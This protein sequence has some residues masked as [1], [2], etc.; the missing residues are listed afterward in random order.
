M[1]L[2]SVS[3]LSLGLKHHEELLVRDLDLTL[4]RG[5]IVGLVGES[6]SG[7]TMV[8]LALLGLLPAAVEVRSG[9]ALLDGAPLLSGAGGAVVRRPGDITMVFQNARA[10]LNPTLRIGFQIR[11]VLMTIRGMPR[12][13]A[14]AEAVRLLGRVGIPGAERVARAYPHQL[15]GGMCQRAVIAM[16]LAFRPRVLIADEPT[17]GLDVTVQAQIFDL[18]RDLVAEMGSSV[19]FI[20]HDLAAVA[21]MCDRVSVLFAGQV[22][23]T[24]ETIELFERPRHPYSE[25]LLASLGPETVVGEAGH[26]VVD[27]SPE[28]AAV[29]AEEKGVDFTLPGCRFAHRCPHVFEACQQYPPLFRAGERHLYSCFLGQEIPVVT[30]ARS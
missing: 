11:R 26:Q 17:T 18:L 1:T 21:E 4:D 3:G 19:L 30:A 2:L 8:S 6:G 22:M 14:E 5:E 23:E 27:G 13:E 7:K 16:A 29:V 12:R 20:T 24:A 15:S 25:F 10:A 28:D 9:T